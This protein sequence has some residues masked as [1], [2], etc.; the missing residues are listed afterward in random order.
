MPGS[1]VAGP[2]HLINMSSPIFD[3]LA[4]LDL[5]Q[6]LGRTLLIRSETE[7]IHIFF[8]CKFSKTFSLGTS[9]T[10]YGAWSRLVSKS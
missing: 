7:K 8:L 3:S 9:L 5:D 10:D 2:D 4:L 1:E 6:F